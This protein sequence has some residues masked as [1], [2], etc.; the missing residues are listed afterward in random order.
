MYYPESGRKDPGKSGRSWGGQPLDLTLTSG[1]PPTNTNKDPE[2]GRGQIFLKVT[3]QWSCS[4]HPKDA[5]FLPDS[6]KTESGITVTLGMPQAVQP[7]GAGSEVRVR[8]DT[9][10]SQLSM[11]HLMCPRCPWL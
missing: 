2:S 9:G 8:E 5:P 1:I 6:E 11:P 3:V 7:G 10:Q 4:P